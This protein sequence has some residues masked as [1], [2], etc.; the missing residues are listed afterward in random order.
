MCK[1]DLI[2]RIFRSFRNHGEVQKN[3]HTKAEIIKRIFCLFGIHEL[4][5]NESKHKNKTTHQSSNMHTKAE[6]IKIIFCSFR[7]HEFKLN[8]SKHKNKTTTS[9]SK[10]AMS[11]STSSTLKTS[12]SSPSHDVINVWWYF[13]SL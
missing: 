6:I 3:M 5:T 9:P 11:Y 2:L 4:K 12:S 1:A 13:L 8:E 7:S 10:S